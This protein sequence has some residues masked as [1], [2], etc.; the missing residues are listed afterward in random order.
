MAKPVILVSILP[1]G[2]AEVKGIKYARFS[3]CIDLK[4][5]YKETDPPDQ[6]ALWDFFKTFGLPNNSIHAGIT[7]S[8]KIEFQ[9][10][11]SKKLTG[12][13]C[14][15]EFKNVQQY[16]KALLGENETELNAL[17]VDRETAPMKNL[18]A[19]LAT[20]PILDPFMPDP[21]IIFS[22]A[23]AKLEQIQLAPG[24]NI[25][26]T[27]I[28]IGRVKELLQ[29][30][31]EFIRDI[32][33]KLKG[34]ADFALLQNRNQSY[35]LLS[36]RMGA[37][38]ANVYSA[39]RIMDSFSF[40]GSNIL[41]QRFFGITIDFQIELSEL[42]KTLG[43]N[44]DF[45][46]RVTQ[47]YD[48]LNKNVDWQ[49]MT[50][51]MTLA[52]SNDNKIIFV[53]SKPV[54][55]AKYKAENYDRGSK[56]KSLELI[57][58]RI[59][60]YEEKLISA[61]KESER[62]AI[63]KEIIKVDSAALTRGLTVY[64]E[65]REPLS[66]AGQANVQLTN[67][68]LIQMQDIV[69][70][71]RFGLLKKKNNHPVIKP[72][73]RRSVTLENKNMKIPEEFKTQDM[74]MSIDS[75]I[76]ALGE[77]EQNEVKEKLLLDNAILT[78]SGEN[79]GMPSVFSNPEDETNFPA[80]VDEGSVDESY[81]LV[82]DAF[83]R[84]FV[85]EHLPK[86]VTYQTQQSNGQTVVTVDGQQLIHI[87]YSS[88]ENQKLLLG[89]DYHL[90]LT[91]EYKNGWGIPFESSTS[92][93]VLNF[94]DYPPHR[95]DVELF[96]FKRNEPVASVVFFAEEE[97][98]KPEDENHVRLPTEGR[99][100]ESLHHLVIRNRSK[101][102]NSEGST[103]QTSVRHVLPPSISFEHAFWHG[104]IFQMSTEESYKWYLKYHFPHDTTHD[105]GSIK[106][107][108]FYP[109]DCEINY[110]P[111]PLCKGFR[112]EF[113]LDKARMI[114]AP[115]YAK[116]EQ[117]EYYFS[118]DYPSINAWKIILEDIDYDEELV[119]VRKER[120]YIRIEKGME[121]FVTA[122]TILDDSYEETF[123]T[124]GNYNDF[125]KYGSNDLLTPPLEF[126]LV[127]ALQR[128]LLA[129]KL[130]NTLASYKERNSS[131]LQL[132]LSL[133]IEQLDIYGNLSG[134][135]K[136]V[137][138]TQP[139]GSIEL[140][141]KWEDY[142]DDPANIIVPQD[143]WTPLKPV[144]H[145][146]LTQF[147]QGEKNSSAASFETFIPVSP[148]Q[149]ERMESNLTRTS[150]D[151]NDSKNYAAD[152]ALT[153]DVRETKYLEKYC[154]VISK[155]KF[156]SYFS[157]PAL[158]AGEKRAAPDL[159]FARLSAAPFLVKILNSKKPNKPQLA[160]RNINLVSVTEEMKIDDGIVRKATMNRLKFYFERG[161]L[162]SGKGERIGFVVNE[163][164]SRYNDYFIEHELMSVVGRD[165]VSDSVKPYDGLTRNSAIWLQKANFVTHDPY[166]LTSEY[167]NKADDIESFS[168]EYVEDLGLMTYLPKFD[169]RLN[170][171]YLEVELDINDESGNELHSP[172]I[173]FA[174]VHY[175]KN[176]FNYKKEAVNPDLL[177]DCR[178]SEIQ[179]SGFVYIMGSR[180]I[181]LNFA[182]K[183]VRISIE[184]DE[185]SLK[186]E[187]LVPKTTAITRSKFYACVQ[188]REKGTLKWRTADVSKE[189]DKAAFT[190]IAQQ[191]PGTIKYLKPWGM[192]YQ[193]VVLETEEWHDDK[194]ASM[195][196][197]LDNK[198]NRVV[199]V[200]VFEL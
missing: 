92:A 56:L 90:V 7:G 79:I 192:Q 138:N 105:Y 180:L 191:S 195:E 183:E 171:W 88:I 48:D 29:P 76:H 32:N 102:I 139:T 165:I 12:T 72:L 64:D 40:I 68:L 112:L 57:E 122:R 91:P 87:I 184:Y 129:P 59:T 35:K 137:D 55:A 116:Y 25:A 52:G 13:F 39:D 63:M 128:P 97:L 69:K 4:S 60:K 103:K 159:Y 147:E 34:I 78:W 20:A 145:I 179:K 54:A 144:N 130:N 27:E 84:V 51:A 181:T 140:Y 41:L 110:L 127:H 135:I 28:E 172:F 17:Q 123:Q 30:F 83:R 2:I 170:L 152:V 19:G 45:T 86:A 24:N 70:G 65:N 16:W 31:H 177:L 21:T 71:Y 124:F 10:D 93:N 182:R 131:I 185:S 1:F 168:P 94:K 3:L 66:P 42:V 67:N 194:N 198:N 9:V 156:T 43:G 120:I 133:N 157:E 193:L 158:K 49:Y 151:K 14:F 114:K 111:D 44:K 15:D 61:T 186:K 58:S 132:A 5:V 121:I 178:L 109:D 50:T 106:M 8:R 74:A 125:T 187:K 142:N 167:G 197:L 136:Y 126:S 174:M 166:N 62:Y 176:S 38:N 161:R 47:A 22:R 81:K 154:W 23:V 148:E 160:S 89:H 95:C 53:K 117:Q 143:N 82:S 33:K 6:M 73:G 85:E 118:G 173:Q 107:K 189:N 100:G 196:A 101:H 199:L 104:K 80:T 96:K 150:N 155:S 175:Q 134:I 11:G 169:I 108:E 99:E 119:V 75:G 18:V 26:E 36:G 115:Q 149:M 188:Q 200:N 163:P 98:L 162:S 164:E 37:L 146:E 190:E 113:Y 141:A 153:Y 77:N 46:I